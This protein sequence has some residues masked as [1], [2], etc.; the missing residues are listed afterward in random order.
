MFDAGTLPGF[1]PE[2]AGIRASEWDA[3]SIPPDLQDRHVA[4][5]GPTE[6]KL[7]F[8]TFVAISTHRN[9]PRTE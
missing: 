4:I 1:L 9:H 3:G 8:N 6:R 2:T 7:T 5:M